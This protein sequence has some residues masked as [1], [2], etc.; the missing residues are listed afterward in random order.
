[1][2]MVSRITL[3][4]MMTVMVIPDHLEGDSD[5]DGIPDYLEDADGDGYSRLS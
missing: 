2:V 4:M 1:M 3:M 5:G